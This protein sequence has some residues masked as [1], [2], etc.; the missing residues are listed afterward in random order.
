MINIYVYIYGS[1]YAC[2]Q[3]H[4]QCIPASL[5]KHVCGDYVILCVCVL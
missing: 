1:E 2:I 4:V 3:V 5:V